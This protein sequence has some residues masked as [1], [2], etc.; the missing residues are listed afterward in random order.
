MHVLSSYHTISENS[1]CSKWYITENVHRLSDGKWDWSRG[2]NEVTIFDYDESNDVVILS[3]NVAFDPSSTLEI[4]PFTDIPTVAEECLFKTYFCPI[5]DIANES[6]Y[7]PLC[8]GPTENKKMYAIENDVN[9]RMWLR[10][11]LCGGSSG[12]VV[13]DRKGRAVGMH[14]ASTSSGLTVENV[15]DLDRQNGKHRRDDD[16]SI[17]SDS[18]SSLANSHTSSQVVL[19]LSRNDMVRNIAI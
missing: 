9:G 7:P 6:T 11:G 4:C 12:G 19:L 18:I 10:G 5:D 2:L 15:K 16:M 13:V 8:A 17:H 1:D 14:V 3:T